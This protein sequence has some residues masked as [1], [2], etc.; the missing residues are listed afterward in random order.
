MTMKTCK[1]FIY[2]VF[3]IFYYKPLGLN[4]PSQKFACEGVSLSFQAAKIQFGIPKFL[5][6][7][8]SNLSSDG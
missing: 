7:I 4:K 3:Q 6:L 1:Y 2:I 5:K 8:Q